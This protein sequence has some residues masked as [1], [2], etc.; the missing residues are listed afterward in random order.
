MSLDSSIMSSDMT[1]REAPEAPQDALTVLWDIGIVARM[2]E[3]LVEETLVDVG[4]SVR[5]F[6]LLSLVSA[7]SPITPSEVAAR[8]GVPATSVSKAM[9]RLSGRGMVSETAH[10]DDGRSRLLSITDEGRS[11]LRQIGDRFTP[12]H[13]AFYATVGDEMPDI[14]WSMRRLEWAL[15]QIGPFATDARE[16]ARHRIPSWIRYS[17]PALT[18]DEESEV[19]QY[20]EWLVHRRG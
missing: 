18:A 19:L 16:A 12:L 3:T 4:I 14:V 20:I 5:E 13:R 7:Q 15:R 1:T 8:S 17:G 6:L 9:A 2:T 10:P 11:T